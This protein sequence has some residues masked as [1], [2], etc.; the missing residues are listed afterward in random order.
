MMKLADKQMWTGIDRF[1]F[2]VQATC[3][4]LHLAQVTK[5]P[6]SLKFNTEWFHTVKHLDRLG[7]QFVALE[8]NTAGVYGRKSVMHIHIE[9]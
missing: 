6:I 4:T 1:V 5:R 2:R 3:T 9:F 7:K 8:H